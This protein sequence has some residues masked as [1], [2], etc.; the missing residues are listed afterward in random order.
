MIPLSGSCLFYF[1][2][3]WVAGLKHIE[4]RGGCLLFAVTGGGVGVDRVQTEQ[5]LGSSKLHA[6]PHSPGV[7]SSGRQ[8]EQRQQG[9]ALGVC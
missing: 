6:G 1:Q 4:L 3:G 9:G 7:I 8:R 2:A 5:Q